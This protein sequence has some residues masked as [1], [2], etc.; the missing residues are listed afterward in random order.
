MRERFVGS[1]A[2]GFDDL[3]GMAGFQPLFFYASAELR[4]LMSVQLHEVEVE[5]FEPFLY[6]PDFRV[7]E[8]AYATASLRQIVGEAAYVAAGAL[9]A[10]EPH[11]VRREGFHLA[12]VVRVAHAAYFN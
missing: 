7:D 2:E 12:D 5:G 3:Q 11:H 9:P 10:D 4:C 6:I 1:H 8:N